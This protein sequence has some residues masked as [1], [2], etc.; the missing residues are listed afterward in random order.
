MKAMMK[1]MTCGTRLSIMPGRTAVATESCGFG[2]VIPSTRSV[3]A[4][5]KMPSTSA[6]SR[7]FEIW[8]SSPSTDPVMISLFFWGI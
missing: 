5:A 3:M 2:G 7:L 6:S 4:K 1:R 8:Y